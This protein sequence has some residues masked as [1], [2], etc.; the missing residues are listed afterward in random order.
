MFS[1]WCVSRLITLSPRL[2][3]YPHFTHAM[4]TFFS[5]LEGRRVV[6]HLGQNC[7]N[8]SAQNESCPANLSFIS[9]GGLLALLVWLTNEQSSRALEAFQ[10]SKKRKKSSQKRA[11]QAGF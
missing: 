1:R 3:V 8:W 5:C 6:P 2:L 11:I 7:K 9:W 4:N 10:L